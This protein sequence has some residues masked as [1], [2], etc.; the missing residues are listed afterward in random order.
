ADPVQLHQADQLRQVDLLVKLFELGLE[1]DV[2]DL[3]ALQVPAQEVQLAQPLAEDRLDRV[4]DQ[5]LGEQRLDQAVGQERAANLLVERA[6]GLNGHGF[7][8]SGMR[9]PS[10]GKNRG[11]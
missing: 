3:A 10:V 2:L 7:H 11:Q 4:G 1:G 5:V 9:L 6:G 8:L